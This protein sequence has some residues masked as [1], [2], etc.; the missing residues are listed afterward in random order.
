MAKRIYRFGGSIREKPGKLVETLGGKGAGLVQMSLLGVKVPPGFVITTDVCREYLKKPG[1]PPTGLEAEMK[2]SMQT[3]EK[4]VGR[5]FGDANDPLLVS[6]RSGA[7]VSMPGMMDTILNLG[8]TRKGVAGLAK[9][10]GN[11][12]FAW[13]SYRRLI[14][15]YSDVVLEVNDELFEHVLTETRNRFG[16]KSDSELSTEA[17][18]DVADRFLAIVEKEAGQPFPDDAWKQLMLAVMAVFR[19]WNNKRAQ[20]YRRINK[21]PDHMG[22]AVNVQTMV[23][24]NRGNLSATGVLFS[25]NPSTGEKGIYG[26]YLVNAQGEDVVAGIRTPAPMNRGTA[27]KGYTGPTLEDQF[28]AI[29]KELAATVVKLEKYFRDMQD[30]EFTVEEGKLWILQTR[31]GKRTARAA[32][33]T[34]TDFVKEGLLKKNEALLRVK[35]KDLDQLMHPIFDPSAKR[36]VLAKGLP[37]SPGAVSGKVVFTAEDA[38]EWA[39]RGEKVIL[40]RAETSPEDI[41][42]MQ[43]AQGIVTSRGGMTSHAAVVARGMGKCC[44]AGCND[45]SVS[46]EE[47]VIV[48]AKGERISEGTVL[49]LDG[50]TGEVLRGALSTVP[51]SLEG[52]LDVFLSWADAVRTLGIRA[53]ADTPVDC[54]TARK[55]GAA[56]VGLCR[57]EH[58]FF[59]KS[60][61][62]WVRRMILAETVEDRVRFLDKIFPFQLEDF[63]GIFREM[64]GFPV[65]VRLLDPPLH[66][67]LPNKEDEIEEL[68]QRLQI[69]AKMLTRR[70]E[71]LHEFNPM[72]G[73]RGCRLGITYPEI[74]RMQVRAIV[75]AAIDVTEQTGKPVYPEIMIPVVMDEREFEILKEDAVAVAEEVKKVRKSKLA[76]LVGTMIELP[77]AALRA[78]EIAKSAQF[79]SFG[80]NDLT[81]TCMG[82]SRDDSSRFLPAYVEKGIFPEDPFASIDAY[83]VLELVQIGTERGRKQNPKL[84][85][86][87]CGEHGGDPASIGYFHK[88]GL[89]YVSCSPRRVPIARLAA[90]QA[91]LKKSVTED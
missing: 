52:L 49:S 83:G 54:A 64:Q 20:T 87:V 13:D 55:L 27:P 15:M 78:G 1:K 86:G 57:T 90:A 42:G 25:R 36:D 26:E 37:A 31:S 75:T 45:L 6:V 77:R 51:P 82:L 29:Y 24:G 59:D 8:L 28:P 7:P 79:F 18:K 43:A 2:K 9:V 22:T 44:I 67:F 50:I 38:E 35:P 84:K 68:A 66:E 73:H 85:V 48:T 4:I 11:E 17:L 60:R 89:N 14:Q 63:R 65:T 69:D 16:V 56:G 34:A 88:L 47:K 32:L 10:Y 62:D 41:G 74:Y 46:A 12:H 91:S 72:L 30:I 76:Y 40:V 61:I 71:K 19:S 80:T 70:I 58:M 81:Q 5:K 53:N 21:L 3:L 23:F 39:N 33:R